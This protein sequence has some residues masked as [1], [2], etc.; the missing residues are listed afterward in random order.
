[1]LPIKAPGANA[2]LV[3]LWLVHLRLGPGAAKADS[4]LALWTDAIQARDVGTLSQL[5]GS[6]F[7]QVNVTSAKGKSALMV[8]AQAAEQTLSQALIDSGADVNACNENGGTPLM[9]AAVSGDLVIVLLFLDSGAKVD[10]QA[11]NGW[12]SLAL[13]ATKGH[14][15]VVHHLLKSG[16]DVNLTDVFGWS[17]LMHATEQNRLTVVNLLTAQPGIKIDAHS[18]KGATALHRAAA[19]GYLAIAQRLIQG[20]ADLKQT[21]N[22]GRT[23]LDYAREAGHPEL[24]EDLGG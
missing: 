15:Q 3:A 16:A 7:S 17:A 8:S 2:L 4:R 21:D 1:M 5:L 6:G 23:A 12:T 24:L 18:V 11:G 9:H 22:E 14:V 20:G 10:A 19:Q 13:A